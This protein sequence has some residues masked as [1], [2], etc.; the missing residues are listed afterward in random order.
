MLIYYLPGERANRPGLLAEHG[1]DR[2]VASPHF[3]ESMRGPGGQG[4]GLLVADAAV[5]AD[6]L[7]IDDSQIW[8]P[9]FGFTSYVGHWPEHV[10]TPA[11]LARDKQLPGDAI[12]LLDG[13]AWT[14]PKLRAW[15]DTDTL[16][17][18]CELPRVMQQ[19]QES[20]K[21][22]LTRVIPGYRALW[23]YS[24]V[25]GQSLFDQ[26]SGLEQRDAAELDDSQA[27]QFSSDL[28]AVNYHVDAS[29]IS[30]LELLSPELWAEV[31]R[32]A[33]DWG[34]LRHHLKNRLSR[35]NSGG[36]NTAPGN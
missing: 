34:T 21:L 35:L 1:L 30:H 5:V 14:I 9:R 24:L 12:E 31:V 10:P 28:L 22:V 2:L 4:A 27:G 33:L 3:R 7:R 16:Q 19:S 11:T 36:T 29:V 13:H 18:H 20:G 15:T 25:I 32:A 17:F 26:L 6:R 23:E 8:S